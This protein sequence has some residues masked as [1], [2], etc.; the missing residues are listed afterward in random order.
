[1]KIVFL[2]F[3]L[4]SC[5]LFVP[6]PKGPISAKG[7]LYT[8]S[9]AKPGWSYKINNKSDYI[10]ENTNGQILLSNSFCEEFQS[11]PL[12]RLAL[13]T[14]NGLKNFKTSLSEYT[15]FHN[16]ESYSLQG[17]GEIDGV[18]VNLKLLNTRRD[19]CYYD[20]VYISPATNKVETEAFSDFLKTVIFP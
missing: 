18:K 8:I 20:F 11:E 13:K 3:I 7:K 6:T 4:S 1:M 15:T 16:R 9:Y 19:N 14:F 5:S 2:S 10:F 17:A 12:D